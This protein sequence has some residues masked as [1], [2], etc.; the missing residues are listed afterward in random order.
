MLEPLLGDSRATT[1]AAGWA[2]DKFAVADTADGKRRM[3]N[4]VTRW[5]TPEKAEAFSAATEDALKARFAG[6]L[7][8]R[9]AAGARVAELAGA[10][11][12]L[13]RPTPKRVELSA[14]CARELA[15]PKVPTKSSPMPILGF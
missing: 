2:G 14:D 9:G 13:T 10:K 11:F 1:V 12:K 8:W 3:L 15:L 7:A 4:W 5:E 6:K